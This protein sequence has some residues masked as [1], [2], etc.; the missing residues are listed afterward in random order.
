MFPLCFRVAGEV[1][2]DALDVDSL[3]AFIAFRTFFPL[4]CLRSLCF[5]HGVFALEKFL[6]DGG[7][8]FF[9]A[10]VSLLLSAKELLSATKFL[11]YIFAHDQFESYAMTL[12]R[13]HALVNITRAIDRSL[14]RHF[15]L[16]LTLRK[17]DRLLDPFIFI[18]LR[19]HGD[20]LARF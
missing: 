10:H 3:A 6:K 5:P 18:L 17:L 4:S 16:E 12:Q 20:D 8:S 1:V 9:K 15:A 11:R 7:E 2:T 19:E 13:F 14:F